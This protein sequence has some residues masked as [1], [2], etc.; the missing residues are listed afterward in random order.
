MSGFLVKITLE[1]SHPPV[2]RRV[3]LPEQI[4]FYHLHEAIQILFGWEDAHLHDF[5][6][7]KS[8]TVV[9][10]PEASCFCKSLPEK[11][12]SIDP[13]L[14]EN[15]WIRYTYDF[16][17]EWQHK[18]VLES[19]VPDYD[20]RY[21][22]IVKVKGDNFDEDSSGCWYEGEDEY[23]DEPFGRNHFSL[24][25]TTKKLENLVFPY[26]KTNLKNSNSKLSIDNVDSKQL[27]SLFQKLVKKALKETSA[28]N[29]VTKKPQ[30][31]SAM[32]VS[33]DTL[34]EF[35][36]HIANQLP[37][38]KEQ[39]SGKYEQMTLFSLNDS[40]P[41]IEE[42]SQKPLCTATYQ[43]CKTVSSKT[44]AQMLTK[45]SM[46]ET[47]DYCKYL[48]IPYNG[49][50]S[51]T[52][53]IDRILHTLSEHPK[54]Y[55][56]VL[57]KKELK[58]LEQLLLKSDGELE[59]LPNINSLVKGMVLGLLECQYSNNECAPVLTIS[60]ATDA[61]Q[62][63]SAFQSSWKKKEYKKIQEISDN[64]ALL[65]QPYGILDMDTLYEKYCYYWDE[66]ITKE[67]LLQV[68]YWHCRM[69]GY[70]QTGD[71]T[72]NSLS[73]AA[74]GEIDMLKIV[75]DIV[76]YAENLPYKPLIKEDFLLWKQGFCN[77]YDN[78]FA[79]EDYLLG[80]ASL[81]K[82]KL[83]DTIQDAFKNVV[84]GIS[85]SEF[86]NNNLAL[87]TPQ[88]LHE[89][90]DFWALI[91]DLIMNTGLAGFK[92]FSREEYLELK[93]ELPPSYLPIQTD[94]SINDIGQKTHIYEMPADIQMQIYNL[95]FH[96][97]PTECADKMKVL[98]QE[99]PVHNEELLMILAEMCLY[100]DEYDHAQKLIKQLRKL[101]KTDSSISTLEDS[102]DSLQNNFLDS[103]INFAD[104]SEGNVEDYPL[105]D[106]L[107]SPEPYRRTE[108]KIG[109]NDPCPCGSGKKYKKCCG[110]KC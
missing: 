44:M 8:N 72:L 70:I 69:C 50:P 40:F 38:E 10:L 36:E 20:K 59:E 48:V 53:L 15:K 58:E 76:M 12:T 14:R 35:A 17:D 1:H 85:A 6:F 37:H 75:T 22:T 55:L 21:V 5:T 43:Y 93:K 110:K 52:S 7:P 82:S 100:N 106:Y 66:A 92:G 26:L 103:P 54:L 77:V 60:V 108:A 107:E 46:Q 11:T 86:I 89:S 104:Y 91:M 51:K 32:A 13:F 39:I 99:I 78:W 109:R 34:K 49:N 23:A 81:P 61:S 19:E 33:V 67:T 30:K 47:K 83:A 62:I 4:S 16:G 105:W 18:I 71:S 80:N 42:T 9:S 29:C 97:D 2:W 64:I 57:E 27:K 41:A 98:V 31:A 25:H 28:Q 84:S 65:L 87:Y 101:N 68:I 90:I 94:T 102:F 79:Y 56:Y 24:E 73:Y 74:L 95:F 63:L 45:L 88:T 3:I 96:T